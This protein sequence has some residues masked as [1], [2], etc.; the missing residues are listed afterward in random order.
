MNKKG[1]QTVGMVGVFMGMFVLIVV[2]V[3]LFQATAQNVGTSTNQITTV[4]LS[5]TAPTTNGFIEL[6]GQEI[7]G[8][9]VIINR[10]QP[11]V[12]N[13]TA[14]ATV[15]TF[16]ENV[17][18]TT[19]V[20]T[21]TLTNNGYPTWSEANTLAITYTYGPDGYIDDSGARSVANLIL[22]FFGLAIALVAMQPTL[23]NQFLGAIGK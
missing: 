4:N 3:A 2:G 21:V 14:N 8:T 18:L 23:R 20:K 15:F 9:P 19:G 6:T 16:A 1:Q 22:V 11:T 10:T 5:V 7:F 17:S 13:Q 12:G